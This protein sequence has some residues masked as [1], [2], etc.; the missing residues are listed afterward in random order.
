MSS[1]I[2]Q[3]IYFTFFVEAKTLSVVD[4]P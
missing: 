4:G 3:K 1:F 2:L